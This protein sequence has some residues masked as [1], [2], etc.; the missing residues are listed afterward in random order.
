MSTHPLRRGC[1]LAQTFPLFHVRGRSARSPTAQASRSTPFVECK[2]DEWKHYRRTV[3]FTRA[4]V[5]FKNTGHIIQGNER[6][7]ATCAV[8]LSCRKC[9]TAMPSE[10]GTNYGKTAGKR[11]EKMHIRRSK[12]IRH[13]GR[14][15]PARTDTPPNG[16]E[17]TAGQRRTLGENSADNERNRCYSA[18]S[19]SKSSPDGNRTHIV[20]TGILYSIH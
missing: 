6:D 14:A 10:S 18:V 19:H 5:P 3:S 20:R 16:R 15:R 9:D 1:S 7:T 4:C 12:Q 11:P 13:K 2:F 17:Q 8:S